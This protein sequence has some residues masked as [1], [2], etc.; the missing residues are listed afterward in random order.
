MKAEAWREERREG[1]GGGGEGV[2]PY[3]LSLVCIYM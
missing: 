2:L 3:Y 1:A